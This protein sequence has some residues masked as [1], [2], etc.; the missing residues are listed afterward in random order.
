MPGTEPLAEGPAG[1]GEATDE[2]AIG[3]EDTAGTTP[4]ADELD[5]GTG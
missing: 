4:D 2:A 3:E 5:E 1:F